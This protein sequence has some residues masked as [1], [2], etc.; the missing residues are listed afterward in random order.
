MQ[1]ELFQEPGFELGDVEIWCLRQGIRWVVGVDEAGRGPLAGPVHAAAVALDLQNLSD[2]LK[3]VLDDS[4]KLSHH[5]REQAYG[6]IVEQVPYWSVTFRDNQVIDEINILQSTLRSMEEAIE[7]VASGMRQIPDRVLIDGNTAVRTE[8]T[9]QTLVKGD[10]RSYAI[11]AASILA[12]VT[13]D[14]LMIDYHGRW[15]EYAFDSNKGYG[16]VAHREAIGTYGPCEIHRLSFG[17]VREHAHRLRG[18]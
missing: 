12:K 3:D 11:A 18:A 10:G 2:E 13:R 1:S 4:K 9:Q 15:P 17:G 14:R 8:L 5:A 16:S 6:L 7:H